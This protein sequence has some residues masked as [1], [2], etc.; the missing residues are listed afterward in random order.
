MV[1]GLISPLA[2][3][4]PNDGT[5]RLFV[6]EQPGT[7]RVI[8][9]GSVAPISF[10]DITSKVESGGE[11]GL[12]GLTFH[13]NFKANGR[14]YVDYTHRVSSSLLQSI[15]AEYK[16]S[17]SNANLADASSERQLLVIPQQDGPN[18]QPFSNHK[19]GQLAFGPDDGFLYIALG[20]GG[21]AGDPFGN[22]QNTNSRLGKILRIGVEPAN[23]QPYTLPA[24]NPFLNGLAPEIFAY[25]LRNPWRF[26]FDR[27]GSHQLLAGDVG[28]SNWEEVDV[29]TKGGNYGWN[30][31]EG[32]H[33]FNPSQACSMSNL[34]LPITEYDHSMN[35]T[36]IVGGF[37]YRGVALPNLLGTY[38]FA[39]FTS[40]EVWGLKQDAS[41]HW[42]QTL[43]FKHNLTVSSFGQDIASE[44]YL[45]DYSNGVVYRL[46]GPQ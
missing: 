43:L 36:A 22:G 38:I 41:G 45:L 40:G 18:G 23:G 15:V 5:N 46:V 17:A 24:D 20:D 8:E 6:V 2:L 27:G 34:I 1:R 29:I 42:Q 28:Q 37:V 16:V 4:S 39:D 44:L 21:G 35:R 12:L 9:N 26:S 14:F 3:E 7:I 13:P 19:G 32:D 25:G 33:C 31:M 30:I 11:E 10:L